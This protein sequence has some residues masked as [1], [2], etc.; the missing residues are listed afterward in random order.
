MRKAPEFWWRDTYTAQSVL[1][2]PLSL[3]YGRIAGRRML[4]KPL[5]TSK[6]PVVCIGNFVVGGAGKTPFAISL[7]QLLKNEGFS[8]AFLLRGYGGA[9]KGPLLVSRKDHTARDVGDEAMLL[10]EVGPTVI[11]A[12]RVE[13]AVTVRGI[14][15]DI[16]VMDDGFQNA[17]LRKDLSIVLVD[18]EKGIGNGHC[19][20]AGPLRAP[21]DVQMVKTNLLMIVGEVGRARGIL[22]R[23]ARRGLKPFHCRLKPL[24]DQNLKGIPFLAFAGIGQPDK[25]FR[26]AK[27]ADLSIVETK[28]FADHHS[29]S[30]KEIEELFDLAREKSLQFLTTAKDLVR[31]KGMRSERARQLANNCRVLNVKMEI[32]EADML[33]AAIKSQIKQRAFSA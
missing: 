23:A 25:F 32:E 16:I 29:F 8:P 24:A 28:A 9:Q 12:D 5:G 15:A 4:A 1:L 3:I 14:G 19:L 27:D 7:Y 2:Y 11:S 31:L 10:A 6:I 30:D 22:R 33:M 18:G 20:P 17:A 26:S 21:I 13:G